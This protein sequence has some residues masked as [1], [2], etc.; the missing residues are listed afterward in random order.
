MPGY[1]DDLAHVHTETNSHGDACVPGIVAELKKAG[2]TNG[3]IVDLG[4]GNGGVCAKLHEA[5]YDTLGVDLSDAF[6][7]QARE[8][9]PH[10]DYEVGSFLSAPLPACRAITALGEVFNY[11]FDPGNGWTSFTKW[12]ARPFDALQPGGLLIFDVIGPGGTPEPRQVARRGDDWALMAH[13]EEDTEAMVLT[14]D[15]TT[16]RKL[17]ALYRR[18]E[19]VHRLHLFEPGEL[20]DVLHE[21]GFEAR[22]VPGL[23]DYLFPIP[24]LFG[25]IARKPVR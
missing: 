3:L 2:I 1:L 6:I 15:I 17:G 8:R 13:I 7:L 11:A 10:L 14:R 25:F 19:E 20:I 12:L 24:G 18:S 22:R 5:G 9:Y 16:F 4:C 21:A 23:G